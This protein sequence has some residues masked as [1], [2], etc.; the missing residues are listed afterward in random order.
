MVVATIGATVDGGVDA[1]TAG[2]GCSGASLVSG[3]GAG[4]WGGALFE[5]SDSETGTRGGVLSEVTLT[6]SPGS[7]VLDGVWTEA[8]PG[9]ETWTGV[10]SEVTLAPDC[11]AGTREEVR[12]EVTLVSDPG[13]G[14]WEGVWS[15]A[16]LLL[17]TRVKVGGD[18]KVSARSEGGGSGGAIIRALGCGQ[19][20]TGGRSGR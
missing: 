19:E 7:E 1:G 5:L 12:S 14:I 15:E 8:T 4:D 6:S 9:T 2:R 16:T 20:S 13:T 18:V 10:W 3:A 11:G 17:G